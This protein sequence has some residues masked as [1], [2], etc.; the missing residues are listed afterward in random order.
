MS[1][2][3]GPVPAQEGKEQKSGSEGPGH[4]LVYGVSQ[5]PRNAR[6][7][8]LY[9][10]Q[11][12]VT[13]FYA[14]VWGF[15]IVGLGLG[16]EGE[17]LTAYMAAVV[18]M[19]GLSTLLQATVGHRMAMV[20]GPN[21]IPSLAIVAAHATGGLDY[22][23]QAFTAQAIAGLVIAV[24]GLAGVLGLIRKVWSPLVLGA[25][26]MMVGL[27]V[28]SVGL[29]QLI[30]LG[31]GWQFLAGAGLAL[32]GTV[33]AIRAKGVL[34]T[35]PPLFVIGV[36]YLLFAV[37]GQ[38]EWEGVRQAPTFA[39]PA[40]FPYGLGLPPWELLLI[41]FVVNLMAA[42]NM[43]GNIHGYAEVVGEKVP[44][45]REK[46]AFGVL[47]AAETGVA[48]VL[49]VPATVPYGENL[50]IVLL[51]R[52][53]ARIFIIVAA[54]VFLLLAFLGPM[55]ALMAAMPEPVSGA[56]LLGIAST[57][58]GIGVKIM[59]DAPAFGRRE[60]SL[61]GFSVF[62]ALGMYLLPGEAWE[63]VPQLLATIF[64][65]P[66]VSV[67]I[68][69]ILFERVVFRQGRK[70]QDEQEKQN[71]QDRRKDNEEEKERKENKE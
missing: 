63:A 32:G 56:V 15:A 6:D 60:Q 44:R 62:L 7:W 59:Q 9:S 3:V 19:I 42:V 49:G 30:G 34:A 65:N 10:F 45:G 39:T 43:F 69:V 48:G 54:I 23:L 12:L 36:G 24:L 1:A 14:V 4:D 18:L 31:F 58:I 68:F 33:L 5:K 27:A 21:I 57:V 16:F 38:I 50:G 25:M 2:C 71:K 22:A 51:T 8:G 67:I 55:G 20:S 46:R 29:E 64:S 13:M 37:T 52:V 26:V 35:L 11:W 41:M 17:V 28:A 47:G 70:K 61:V 40:I 66:V 53:A